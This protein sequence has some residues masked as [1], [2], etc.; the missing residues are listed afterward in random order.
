M[1]WIPETMRRRSFQEKKHRVNS[2]TIGPLMLCQTVMM[3][4]WTLNLKNSSLNRELPIRKR[5]GLK[6]PRRNKLK[7]A[8]Q[9]KKTAERKQKPTVN[10][11]VGNR[12]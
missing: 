2:H 11:I 10:K 4:K 6:T 8:I 12:T 3:M 9:E 7:K 5:K 1:N